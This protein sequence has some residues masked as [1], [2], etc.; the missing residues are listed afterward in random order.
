MAARKACMDRVPPPP[1]A[2][3]VTGR[4]MR[5]I[6]SRPLLCWAGLALFLAL[7]GDRPAQAA[8]PRDDVELARQANR[9]LEEEIKLAGSARIYLLLDLSAASLQIKSRGIELHRLRVLGWDRPGAGPEPLQGVFRLVT[10]PPVE[11]PKVVPEPGKDPETEPINLA[12]MPAEYLLDFEPLLGVAVGPPASEQP[13]LWARGRLRGAWLRLK[14]WTAA[15]RQAPVQTLRLTLSTE[16]ARSLAWSVTDGMS[17]LIAPA[18]A[19]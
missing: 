19:P 5:V 11:R 8:G 16:E 1:S 2:S 14:S 13:W 17:L 12:D 18:T 10:R 15:G 3:T 4:L 6:R 7:P 9:A